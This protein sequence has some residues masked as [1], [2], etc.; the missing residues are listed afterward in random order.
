MV[1]TQLTLNRESLLNVLNDPDE[2]RRLRNLRRPENLLGAPLSPEE[3][4][5][6]NWLGRLKLLHGVPFNYIVPDVNMLPMESIRFFYVDSVWLDYLVEGALSLGRSTAGDSVHDQAFLGD[7]HV[8]S[9]FGI[10]A[11]RN[12]VLGHLTFHLSAAEKNRL[13]AN[14]GPIQPTEKITGFLLR[15]GVVSGWDGLKVEAFLDDDNK[16]P[17]QLL[18]MD[19]LSPNVLMCIY[20]GMVKK[21]IIHEYP[22]VLHFGVD[23][24]STDQG[25]TFSKSFR[26]I[27]DH[28]GHAAG[29]QVPVSIAPPVQ[30]VDFK[31]AG[32]VGVLRINDLAEAMHNELSN[33]IAYT[34]PFTAAEFALEMVEGVEAVNF[35]IDVTS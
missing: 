23:A 8:F 28:D 1:K 6:A 34:G 15:S 30:I 5:L 22:E 21:V 12:N 2:L 7:L 3:Q 9:R 16:Q 27:V 31:R 35:K 19:H 26:Y 24:D 18:R 17:A 11:Q 14:S 29:T 25:I 33:K 10:K 20:E 4:N 32:S 13:T